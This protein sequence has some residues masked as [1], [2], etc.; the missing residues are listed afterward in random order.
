MS[1]VLFDNTEKPKNPS[2][3]HL[4]EMW[5]DLAH[6]RKQVC[7]LETELGIARDVI[8]TQALELK[9][10][11]KDSLTQVLTRQSF[12]ENLRDISPRC[13]AKQD[14]SSVLL[15]V[16]LNKFKQ[17]NDTYGHEVGDLALQV[18]ARTLEKN[19]CQHDL[20]ARRG[21]D[22]F[23]V[24]LQDVDHAG[25]EKRVGCIS[26]ALSDLSF[27]YYGTMINFSASVGGVQYDLG[28]S[29]EDNMHKAD[30][31][32]YRIKKERKTIRETAPFSGTAPGL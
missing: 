24:Y 28:V 25:L 15:M 6:L 17:I 29:I 12:V 4:C 7:T 31:S 30:L 18:V 16:D 19:A 10:A 9:E 20:V 2:I 3:P 8:E 5:K 23:L 13:L 11:Q 22:E 32:M 26:E 14:L 21:G 27:D 1:I